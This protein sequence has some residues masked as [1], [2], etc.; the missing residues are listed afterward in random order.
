MARSLEVVSSRGHS[1]VRT[2]RHFHGGDT[3]VDSSP[4]EGFPVDVA[5]L[6]YINKNVAGKYRRV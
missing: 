1:A 2:G 5:M 6:K 4:A 3:V